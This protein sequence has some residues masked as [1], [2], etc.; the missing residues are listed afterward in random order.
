MT[1][2]AS[3]TEKPGDSDAQA[4]A[5]RDAIAAFIDRAGEPTSSLLRQK[6]LAN[7]GPDVYSDLLLEV[8]NLRYAPAEAENIWGELTA[9]QRRLEQGVGRDLGVR[10]AALD[11]F[12][13]IRHELAC[14]KIVDPALL[15]RLERDALLDPLTGLGN[16]RF[17][18]DKLA[19]ELERS[20]RYRGHFV[21]AVFDVDNFKGV[22]DA[23]GHVEGDRVLQ[24]L[25]QIIRASIRKTDLAARWGGEEFIVLMPQTSKRGAAM[26]AE[27]LRARVEKELKDRGVT[28]SGGIAGYPVDGTDESGLFQFADRALHR[29][30]SEGKNRIRLTPFE[31]R[32]FPRLD[33]SLRVRLSAIDGVPTT[34]TSRTAELEA[35]TANISDG[36]IAVRQ[37]S[38]AA[39]SSQVHGEIEIRQKKADFVGRV[40][41][42]EEA[43]GGLYDVGIQFVSIDKVHREL[44]LSYSHG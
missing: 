30:K 4:S 14:P 38:T 11:F 12:I 1:D 24:R 10:V 28:V 20:A 43:G 34:G 23:W 44:I 27:R 19:A 5:T 15:E 25:A 8:A 31:R 7:R 21:V 16:R 37:R 9:H 2:A 6:I 22:N 35:V 40:V 29:A 42:V 3:S 13:N 36:G 33:E 32:S 41:Y 39:V 26:Q 17:Y 18:R